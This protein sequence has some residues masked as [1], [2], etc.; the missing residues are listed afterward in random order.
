MT[1]VTKASKGN[2]ILV[3]SK[4]DLIHNLLQMMKNYKH[5]MGWLPWI[6]I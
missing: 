1:K 2:V 5:P 3:M 6:I 4:G